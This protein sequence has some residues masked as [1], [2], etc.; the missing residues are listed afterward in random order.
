MS[1]PIEK[2]KN[3]LINNFAKPIREV[4]AIGERIYI[5]GTCGN[6][7]E[8]DEIRKED[9]SIEVIVELA[10]DLG[11]EVKTFDNGNIKFIKLDQEV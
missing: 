4:P 5:C 2:A 6:P 9:N 10:E 7:L 8:G 3:V 11:Y 1:D